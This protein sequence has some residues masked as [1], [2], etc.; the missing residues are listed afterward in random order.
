MNFPKLLKQIRIEADLT[1]K[2]LAGILNVSHMLIVMMENGSRQPSR[3]FMETLAT[4]LN[5]HPMS[6]T[7]FI[8]DENMD[9][10]SSIEKKLLRVG[11][12][13]QS[14]LI[15]GRAKKLTKRD[16]INQ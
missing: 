1:Q 6:L 5:V 15:L 13:L 9:D 12:E 2:E 3:K 4:A 16:V 10:L 11:E 7:P 14:K 8:F